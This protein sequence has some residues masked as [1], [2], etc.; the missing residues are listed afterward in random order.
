M[1]FLVVQ[2]VHDVFRCRAAPAWCA[3]V[4]GAVIVSGCTLVRGLDGGGPSQA[5]VLRLSGR[6]NVLDFGADPAGTKDSA[7]AFEA[8][9]KAAVPFRHVLLEIPPGSYLFRR[10][11]HFEVRGNARWT[12]V[13][14]AGAGVGVSRLIADN[15]EGLLVVRGST[16]NRMVLE[17]SGLSLIA[18]RDGAGIA[19]DVDKA[20]PGVKHVRQLVVRNVEIRGETFSQG[21]FRTGFKVRNVWFPYFSNVTVADR[22]GPSGR[23]KKDRMDYGFYLEDSY[24]PKFLACHVWGGRCALY[25][26]SPRKTAGPEDGTI[27][28]CWFVDCDDGIVIRLRRDHRQ[29]EEPGMHVTDC[30]INYHDHGI[31]VEGLRQTT[32]SHC[33][34]YCHDHQG[35]P[36]FGGGPPGEG[37]PVD[38]DLVYAGDVLISGNIFT[39]PSNPKRIAVRIGR[40]S[41]NILITGNQF[42]IEGT[43]V[44]NESRRPSFASGNFFRGRRNFSRGLIKYVDR[45][46]SLMTNDLN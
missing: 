9:F 30:H 3:A 45:T 41:G 20:N 39:E 22:Y 1:Q 40:D 42:N 35:S 12:G 23:N 37:T 36:F 5:S 4:V 27:S 15:D 34:F 24:N 10:A 46:G 21:F 11:A 6:V 38:V 13:H 31:L 26:G 14:F 7:P 25:Y 43:A 44:Q 2:V 33:L 28:N 19:V 18:R 8:A 17:L 16:T 29:W 32:I